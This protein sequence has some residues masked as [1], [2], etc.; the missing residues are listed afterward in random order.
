[1]IYKIAVLAPIIVEKSKIISYKETLFYKNTLL[2]FILNYDK[3]QQYMFF[4]GIEENENT[5]SNIETQNEIKRFISVMANVNLEFYYFKNSDTSL[6]SKWN[7]LTKQACTNYYDY[8][9]NI[10][11][12]TI[13]NSK[14]W[15]KTALLRIKQNNNIGFVSFIDKTHSEYDVIMTS[16]R[17]INI[18]KKMF[19]NLL[20]VNDCVNW[21]KKIYPN[22]YSIFLSEIEITKIKPYLKYYNNNIDKIS[23]LD[24][25]LM[26]KHYNYIFQ[27]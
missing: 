11:D 10:T 26:K 8:F 19:N 1:M 24:I 9:I 14:N 12:M 16:A 13:F 20:N 7:Y 27:E 5:F 2:S 4:V 3:S 6:V 22:K 17:H 21:L 23:K 25:I 18:F 15:V